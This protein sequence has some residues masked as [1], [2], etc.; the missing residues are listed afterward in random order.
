MTMRVHFYQPRNPNRVMKWVINPAWPQPNDVL[1]AGTSCSFEGNL[2][3]GGSDYLHSAYL[4]FNHANAVL[5]L[6][7]HAP[8]V[9]S[10]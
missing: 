1:V 8:S 6:I 7:S 5:R 4:S 10:F 9:K 2:E 3:S